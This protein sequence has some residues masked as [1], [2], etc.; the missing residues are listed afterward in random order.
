MSTAV[1][2]RKRTRKPAKRKP[3]KP[4]PTRVLCTALKKNGEPCTRTRKAGMNVCASHARTAHRPTK[5]TDTVKKEILDALKMGVYR[6]DAAAYAGVSLSVFDDWSAR[7]RKAIEAGLLD[8]E[9]AQFLAACELTTAKHKAYL[10]GK[11]TAAAAK[12]W[13]AAIE[14]L[15]RMYPEEYGRKDAKF[16]EHSG[17]VGV[18]HMLGGRHPFQVSPEARDRIV[19]ILE[20]ENPEPIDGTAE[21]V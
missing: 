13:R 16:I 10:V 20:E 3:A 5:F 18:E 15:S 1:A 12:D 7:G 14:L 21:E 2:E 9:Y 8:D 17:T 4:K 11:V 6:K 19:A